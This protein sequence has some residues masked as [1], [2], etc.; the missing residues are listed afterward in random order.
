MAWVEAAVG[1]LVDIDGTLIDVGKGAIPGAAEFLDRLHARAVPYKIC[2]NT[3]RRS[4][5]EVARACG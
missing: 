3:S 4:R 2:S 5:A 1:A